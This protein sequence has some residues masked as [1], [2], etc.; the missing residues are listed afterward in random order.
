MAKAFSKEIITQFTTLGVYQIVG[1]VIGL[2]LTVLIILKTTVIQPLILFIIVVAL[3]L[4][5]YSIYCGYLLLR[6]KTTGLRHS[7]FNQC[8]QLISFSYMGYAF[9]YLSGIYFLIGLDLTNSIA[10]NFGLGFSSWQININTDSES[11]IV[12]LNLVALFIVV[13]IDKIKK[14]VKAEEV[15]AE[16]ENIGT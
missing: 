3:G 11:L 5:L 15:Q 13:Y 10:F 7:T 16:V 12:N 6:R 1:G 9:Q 8:L 2:I 14:Q 4:Y